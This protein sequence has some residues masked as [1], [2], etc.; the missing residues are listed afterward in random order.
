LH[1]S[2]P[3]E[4]ATVGVSVGVMRATPGMDADTVLRH[5]DDAMYATKSA[6]RDPTARMLQP[7]PWY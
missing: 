4:A 2:E 6:R 5:A 7:A 1:R 3:A